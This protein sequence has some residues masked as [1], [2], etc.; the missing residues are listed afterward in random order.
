MAFNPKDRDDVKRFVFTAIGETILEMHAGWR[1]LEYSAEL[2]G[3][4]EEMIKEVRTEVLK[5]VWEKCDELTKDTPNLEA[6]LE[7]IFDD[8]K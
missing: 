1:S 8:T 5:E 2:N 6:L 7:R 4:P 3:I